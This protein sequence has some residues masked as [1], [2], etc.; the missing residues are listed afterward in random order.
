MTSFSILSPL[1]WYPPLRLLGVRKR[2]AH[3]RPDGSA[4]DNLSHWYI[5]SWVCWECTSRGETKWEC[6]Y[7]K[8][9][10]SRRR[11]TAC[12][13]WSCTHLLL[14]EECYARTT[15]RACRKI[16]PL[17]NKRALMSASGANK[18]RQV[19]LATLVKSH[20]RGNMWSRRRQYQQYSWSSVSSSSMEN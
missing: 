11:T 4:I 7:H 9:W 15:H 2:C 1:C 5:S 13:D 16:T 18:K 6:R 14:L 3:P 17:I 10:M 20:A 12:L 8:S 19:I